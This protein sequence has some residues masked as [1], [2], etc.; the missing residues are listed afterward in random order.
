MPSNTLNVNQSSEEHTDQPLPFSN[1]VYSLTRLEIMPGQIESPAVS[2]ASPWILAIFSKPLHVTPEYPEQ[3]GPPS[4]IARWNLES[5]LPA[6][7]PKFDE[8]TSKKSNGNAKVCDPAI[9]VDLS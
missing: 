1:S 8:V 7:H 6:S 9:I 3:Q 5:A 4:L 2:T